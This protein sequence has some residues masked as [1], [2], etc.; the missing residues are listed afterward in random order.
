MEIETVS[1]DEIFTLVMIMMV[2]SMFEGNPICDITAA[3]K[4]TV[5]VVWS[6]PLKV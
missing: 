6:D 2:W 5:N 4:S 3:M 1:N